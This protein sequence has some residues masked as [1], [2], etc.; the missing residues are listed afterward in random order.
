MFDLAS[1][2]GE[3]LLFAIALFAATFVAEDAATI[4]AGVIV[5]SLGVDPWL[6]LAAVISGTAVGDLALYGFGRW[7]AYTRFGQKVRARPDVGRMLS[8][9]GRQTAGLLIVARFVPGMR[10]PVFTASG[11]VAAPL[12]IVSGIIA[13]T[14]PVWTIML[15]EIARYAGSGA[16]NELMGWA[17]GLGLAFALLL[18]LPGRLA[19]HWLQ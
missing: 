4:A 14:T 11:V 8:A 2:A 6:A 15:F 5:G 12:A 7:G 3:P 10:L 19:R 9:F 17:L 16:A 1:L 13:I 18:F